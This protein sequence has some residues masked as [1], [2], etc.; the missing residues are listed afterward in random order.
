MHK[1][2]TASRNKRD[3]SAGVKRPRITGA[4]AAVADVAEPNCPI[5]ADL[6]RAQLTPRIAVQTLKLVDAIKAAQGSWTQRMQ[7]VAGQLQA[8]ASRS[9]SL[10]DLSLVVEGEKVSGRIRTNASPHLALANCTCV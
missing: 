1:R 8:D 6:E 2:K 5:Q 4:A 3:G 9:Q 7:T 10:I